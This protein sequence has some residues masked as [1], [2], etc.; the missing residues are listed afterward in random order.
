MENTY[1]SI[2]LGNGLLVINFSSPHE[3]TFQTGEILPACSKERAEAMKVDTGDVEAELDGVLEDIIDVQLNITISGETQ[4]EL[5]RLHFEFHGSRVRILVP[6]MVL[7]GWYVLYPEH[8]KNPRLHSFRA[9][10]SADRV[11]KQIY[12]NK[13]CV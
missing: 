8:E 1:T 6:L 2:T 7:K 9:V 10:R 4:K 5:E 11:T 12:R 13:F 3:F